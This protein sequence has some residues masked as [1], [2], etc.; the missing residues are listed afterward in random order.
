MSRTE[1]FLLGALGG[2]LPILVS[3]LTV[4]LAPIIDHYSALTPGN[5]IGYGIR[6]LVLLIL[7]GTMALLNSEVK[8]PFS[9]VQLGI[10]APAL[11]TSFING[12]PAAAKP[13]VD[14]AFFA[15]ISTASAQ[16]QISQ[17]RIRLAG[18]LLG[19]VINNVVPGIGTR[20]DTLNETNRSAAFSN[21]MSAPNVNQDV[22][23]AMPVPPSAGQ[24]G[25]GTF[26]MTAIGK[27]GPGPVAPVG[28]QCT[29]PTPTGPTF[30][31][32]AQ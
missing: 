18:G 20:L 9:L 12:A 22:G 31:F 25:F 13:Q 32:V 10:A 11:V 29:I 15:I 7:G 27:F 3:L 5:Y 21:T 1:M 16:D 23:Q 30:G 8:Q 24:L 6:V 4:D 19:D 26:C 28:S 2:L 14:H 17:P